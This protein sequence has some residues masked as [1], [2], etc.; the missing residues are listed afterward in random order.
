MTYRTVHRQAHAEI[1]RKKSRFF[2]LAAPV[3]DESEALALIDGARDQ[4]PG[5][6]HHV[7]A[8]RLGLGV[9]LLRFSDDGEPSGTAGMPVLKVLEGEDLRQVVVVVSRIFGGTLLGTGGLARAYSDAAR[10]AL[11]AARI[12]EVERHIQLSF[13]VPYSL[14]GEVEYTLHRLRYDITTLQ[15][16]ADVGLQVEI[17]WEEE[18]SFRGWIQEI[19]ADGVQPVQ[20]GSTFRTRNQ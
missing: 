16:G 12:V 1:V 6:G 5:A 3:E 18:A 4:H 9:P 2:S 11:E 19:S 10:A 8:Y 13:Q 20:E 15:F 17:P 7:F 14:W